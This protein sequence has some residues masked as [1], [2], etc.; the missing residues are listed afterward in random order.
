M[1]FSKNFILDVWLCSEYSSGT[2]NC[3]RQK[4]HLKSLIGLWICLCLCW[5]WQFLNETSK[6]CYEETQKNGKKHVP[7]VP[8]NSCSKIFS[9]LDGKLSTGRPVAWL[10]SLWT[11]VS[12]SSRK[13]HFSIIFC[14]AIAIYGCT[15]THHD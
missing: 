15:L 3:C 5:V 14:F 9:I 11:L 13:L 8:R 6:I 1:F 10:Q 7:F 12:L 4:L 2:V